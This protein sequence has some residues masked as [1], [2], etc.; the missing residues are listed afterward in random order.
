MK[1][2][3]VI[4]LFIVFFAI[5]TVGLFA[6]PKPALPPELFTDIAI[7]NE[8]RVRID[9]ILR[10]NYPSSY[11]YMRDQDQ[12]AEIRRYLERETETKTEAS[13]MDKILNKVC[14]S[15]AYEDAKGVIHVQP[16]GRKFPSLAAYTEYITS[17]EFD[18]CKVVTVSR[19][20]GPQEGVLGGSG[21]GT[22]S[23]DQI[24]SENRDRSPKTYLEQVEYERKMD[25]LA[26]IKRSS[27]IYME[28]YPGEQTSVKG[29]I[30]SLDDYEFN[31]VFELENAPRNA[32][33]SKNVKDSL[34]SQ[35]ILDWSSLPFNSDARAEQE[36]QFIAG[37]LED[38]FRDP[39]SGVFFK[40]MEGVDIEPPDHEAVAAREAK[41]LSTYQPTDIT[42]H[43]VDSEMERVAKVVAQTYANDPDWEPVI[44]KRG[45]HQYAVTELRPRRKKESWE[46]ETP[47]VQEAKDQGLVAG[48]SIKPSMSVDDQQRG[49]PYF[50]KGGV[51]DYSNNKFWNYNEFNK[52][53][54][55]LERMFAPTNP[56]QEWT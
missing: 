23:M 15:S 8:D 51:L 50:D 3:P 30:N 46:S 7:S 54:P 47:S 10:E 44:E 31:R 20:V 37:R 39:K 52:W 17:S 45:E 12:N 34:T 35:R 29:T 33:L 2:I 11:P 53:T 18:G 27:D 19:Y 40:N 38:G 28:Q 4:I 32:A 55:G 41:I 5:V 36:E 25:E 26:T 1:Q 43:V 48:G 22:A 6:N 14:P 42:T 16:S 49:D 56:T 9:K 24:A 21:T 13:R